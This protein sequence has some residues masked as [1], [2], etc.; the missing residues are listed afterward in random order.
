MQGSVNLATPDFWNLDW[1]GDWGQVTTVTL[2]FLTACRAWGVSL[3]VGGIGVMNVMVMTV[4]ERRRE[5]GVRMALGARPSD[6][7]RL[8]LLEA[9][10]L[11]T[12][13]AIAGALVGQAAA[14]LFVR[15][16]GWSVFAMSPIAIPLGIGSAITTGLF[17]GLAPA[18]SAAKL[19]PVYA[20]R[21]G[22]CV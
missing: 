1:Y 9:M 19:Q 12:T 16:T 5:I 17:F 21:V 20:L 6:I 18:L 3:L 7:A 2:V 10:M 14:W 4:A 11:A 15:L 8:F 13:G 22:T